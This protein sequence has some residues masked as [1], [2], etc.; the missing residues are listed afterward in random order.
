MKKKNKA[1]YRVG[2]D[3]GGTKMLAA[4]FNAD[5]K[6]VGSRRRKTKGGAGATAGLARI[7]ETIDQ[8][9][10]EAKV[11]RNQ[12]GSIG[13]GVPGMLDLNKGILLQAPNLGWKDLPLRKALSK[14]FKVPV[15]VANDVDAGT[16][17]EYRFGAARKARCVVGVFPGTG[18]GGACVY[19]GRILRGKVGS[20]M[21]IGHLQV[22]PEGDYCG[23][24]RRGCLETVASRLAISAQLAAAAFRGETPRLLA[25]AGT[26]LAQ[27]RSGVIAA[28]IAG[29][30]KAVERIVR[31]AAAQ[32]GQAMVGLVHLLNPDVFVLGGGL[33]EELP[34]LYRTEV[35]EALEDGVLPAFR[36]SYKVVI[37]RLGD[38]ATALGAAALAAD[39]AEDA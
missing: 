22:R 7:I 15:G 18:I 25:M 35:E 29:G 23:C 27:I 2:F 5:F 6:L 28:A 26:E 37:A 34:G 11:R 12:V 39:F 30:E 36:D 20:C 14:E 32:L 4:V 31:A 10:A 16:Y 17:G 9:L 3:L 33:V 38:Q 8:A 19:E 21:E 24:G 13:L 1:E